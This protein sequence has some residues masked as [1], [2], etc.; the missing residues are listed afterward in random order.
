[1]STSILYHAFGLKGIHYESNAIS[2][3]L[4]LHQCPNDGSVCEVP[5]MHKSTSQFQRAKK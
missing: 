5:R 4:H 3:E 1:M 2:L